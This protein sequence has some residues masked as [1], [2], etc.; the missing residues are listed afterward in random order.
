MVDTL[1]AKVRQQFS[2]NIFCIVIVIAAIKRGNPNS[3]EL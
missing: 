1:N 2:I 3:R